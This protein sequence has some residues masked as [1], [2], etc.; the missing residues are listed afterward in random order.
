MGQRNLLV[1]NGNCHR[2]CIFVG[3]KTVSQLSL[4]CLSLFALI[5]C[6][7]HSVRG[8]LAK[9][10]GYM[11]S[12]P[13]SALLVLNQLDTCRIASKKNRARYSLLH[14]MAIDRNYIDTTDLGILKNAV[15]Y[16]QRHGGAKDRMRAFY[17]QGRLLFN[18]GDYPSAIV[19]FRKSLDYSN[20]LEDNWMK[21][22]ICSLLSSTYNYN[23]NKADELKYAKYALDFFEKY[24]DDLYVDNA[25]FGLALAYH[26]NR[27]FSPSD[28]LYRIIITNPQYKIFAITGLANNAINENPLRPQDAVKNFEKA[29]SLGATLSANDMYRYAYALILDG[30]RERADSILNCAAGI[31][32]DVG[33]YWWKYCIAKET[34]AKMD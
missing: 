24:G 18:R 8:D 1:K 12:H 13:D 22:M 14:T 30:K 6:S 16:Y 5:S 33:T 23:Y 25:R 4:L 28:S 2:L 31:P 10:D 27:L 21:G 32:V 9:A 17:Y 15:D 34:S 3:M 29:V 19:A 20:N 11:M 26:N 7:R